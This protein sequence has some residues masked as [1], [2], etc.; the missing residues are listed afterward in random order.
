M[1]PDPTHDSDRACPLCHLGVG[2][3]FYTDH[4]TYFRCP[5]CQLVF[6]PPQFFLSRDEENAVYD[7][8][9]NSPD[10]QGYRDF[11]GRL[12]EPMLQRLSPHSRGLDFGSGPGPTLSL[13]FEESGHQMEI[14]DPFYAPDTTPLRKQYDFITAT[15]VLEHLHEPRRELDQLWSCLKCKGSLGI[16]TKRVIDGEAFSRWHYKNDPTHVC[17]YSTETFAW[18]AGYWDA[19][20]TILEDD[21]VIF[22]KN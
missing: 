17:F 15:E 22:T 10:D 21:V 3:D 11:L 5:I 9:Q 1:L 6:V 4:R 13:M 18:L 19:T 12:F 7:Q 8:H 20:M 16:M 2:E 14:Y